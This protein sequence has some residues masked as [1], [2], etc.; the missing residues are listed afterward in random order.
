M[1]DLDPVRGAATRRIR[2]GASLADNPF[3]ALL[4]P[5]TR[6]QY[7]DGCVCVPARPGI[8]IEL[9]ESAVAKYELRS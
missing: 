1:R 9:D 6:L 7:R 4:T 5:Q 8:G 2:T 3:E